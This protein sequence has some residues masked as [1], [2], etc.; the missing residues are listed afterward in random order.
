MIP[1]WSLNSL[2]FEIKSQLC[3]GDKVIKLMCLF[4]LKLVQIEGLQTQRGLCK[5]VV[6]IA[7]LEI[8][9]MVKSATNNVNEELECLN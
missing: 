1:S 8:D 4:M 3:T 5:S 9:K 2:Y 7:A 6:K